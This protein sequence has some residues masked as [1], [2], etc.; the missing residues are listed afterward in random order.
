MEA[1]K[2][3]SKESVSTVESKATERVIAT[4]KNVKKEM[5]T[6]DPTNNK[7]EM[8]GIEEVKA[9]TSHSTAI[10]VEKK[11]ISKKTVLNKRRAV[12]TRMQISLR[13][14]RWSWCQKRQRGH[15]SQAQC[16][17]KIQV[18]IGCRC[19]DSASMML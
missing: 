1:S 12:E 4:R 10:I 7:V 9:N 14:Q 13:K 3:V 2:S 18:A 6:Q 11:V 19:V 17:L 15:L 5:G 16:G 8:A